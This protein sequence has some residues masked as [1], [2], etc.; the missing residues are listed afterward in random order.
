VNFEEELRQAMRRAPAPADFAGR[1]LAKVPRSAPRP[2]WR[3]PLA[4]GLAAGLLMAAAIPMGVSEYKRRERERGLKATKQLMI[5]L[6]VTSNRL[7]QTKEKI[8]RATR[9]PL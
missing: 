4:L 2:V 1:V 5:A 3:R 9:H 8:E 7:R 6:R